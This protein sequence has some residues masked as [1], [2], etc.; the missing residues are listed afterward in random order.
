MLYLITNRRLIKKGNLYT[1]VLESLRGGLDAV[2]LREKDLSCNE[3]MDIGFKLKGLTNAF[4]ARLIVNGNP[5]VSK[6]VNAD[7]YHSSMSNFSVDSV[8]GAPFGLSTH[9]IDDVITAK[10][11]GANY[12]LLSHIF[13]TQC[14]KGLK[15]KGL[16]II[17]ESKDAIDMPI[18]ALGG[19]NEMNIQDIFMAGAKGAAVMS[20]IMASDDPYN[21]TLTLKK[22][23]K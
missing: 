12:V 20:Y 19:I 15:P 14:K 17:S 23:V 10:K 6:A 22:M 11:L 13:P 3:L 7:Y 21:A 16:S 2:I 9:S 8:Y 5:Y 18:I 4:G 1:V